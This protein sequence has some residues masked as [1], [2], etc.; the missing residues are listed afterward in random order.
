MKIKRIIGVILAA[1]VSASVMLM[2]IAANAKIK[3]AEKTVVPSELH[4]EG[5]YIYNAEGEKVRLAGANIPDLQWATGGDNDL[6]RRIGILC[7]QWN[8]NCVRLCVHSKFWFGQEC[9]RAAAM[10]ITARW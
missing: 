7:D 1:A 5:R 2:P 8:A 10:S 9:I 6:N 3:T 4:V